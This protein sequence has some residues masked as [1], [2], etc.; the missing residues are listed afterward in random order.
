MFSR[1]LVR[2]YS[3]ALFSRTDSN[4]PKEPMDLLPYILQ[5]TMSGLRTFMR[6]FHRSN[7][8]SVLM[9][10]MATFA[11]LNSESGDGYHGQLRDICSSDIERLGPKRGTNEGSRVTE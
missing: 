9:S 7:S 4:E 2:K 10:D 3:Q 8:Q 11:T 1:G 5:G 6:K